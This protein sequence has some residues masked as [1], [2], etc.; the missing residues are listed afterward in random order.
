MLM[1][2][3][4]EPLTMLRI[5]NAEAF[6]MPWIFSRMGKWRTEMFIGKLDGHVE[7]FSPWL[8]GQ[9]ITI[10]VTPNLEFGFS[11]TIVFAGGGR[12]LASSFGRS[13]ISVG[14]PLSAT[15]GTA[16]D[17][18]D[19]RGGFDFQYRLPKL[20]N[21][22]TLYADS[23]TDDDPSPLSAPH[24]AAFLSGLYFP[25]L[26]GLKKMDLR[27][28]SAFT[29]APGVRGDGYF[30]YVNG[31]YVQSY[32]NDGQLLGHWVG[33][34]GKAYEGWATYWFST[35]TKAQVNVRI[36]QT[37]TN[38]LPGGGRQ[39]DFAARY[40]TRLRRDTWLAIKLQ[41]EKWRIPVLESRGRNNV[42]VSFQATYHPH[43]FTRG[44]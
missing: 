29:D 17:V 5:R 11:R 39:W 35:T 19:R 40:E 2:E 15:P 16:V 20:R 30:F 34:A 22:V 25:R 21:Y 12:G 9:K 10:A 26:P 28:E 13:F 1:G 44:N 31:G 36:L 24:R 33:R 8:Q 6:R 18:G 23:F 3:N 14:A 41:G 42:S 32:T 38:Y 4:A 37:S 27:L 7:P 43:W